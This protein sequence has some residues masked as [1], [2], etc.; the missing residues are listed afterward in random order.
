MR[1]PAEKR[2][3]AFIDGQNLFYAVKE[4]FGYSYPNY[5]PLALATKICVCNGWKLESVSFY[6]GV[7][8]FQDKPF[9]NE[10]WNK[11]L[12][13]MGTRGIQVFRRSLRYRNQTIAL[14]NGKSTTTLVGQEKGIDIRIALDMVRT[15]HRKACDVALLFSQ[16]QDLTEAV[17]EVKIIAEEQGRWIKVASAFPRSPTYRNRRGIDKTDWN[18][19]DRDFYD[20]C[21]DPNDYRPRKEISGE[22]V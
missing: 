20:T 1:E 6:T 4:A 12:A 9:W 3:I 18:F 17:Q 5:D 2:T 10:F 14:P 16:D 11:K 8:D 21:L 19:I 7:P 15:A 22:K 13:V